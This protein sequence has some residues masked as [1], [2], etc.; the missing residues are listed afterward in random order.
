[1]SYR[2]LLDLFLKIYRIT[3]INTL[4]TV[5]TIKAYLMYL[6]SIPAL[7]NYSPYTPNTYSWKLIRNHV[8]T[9]VRKKISIVFIEVIRI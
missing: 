4:L 6:E 8:G 2:I 9:T 1:M 7:M 3:N 5:A